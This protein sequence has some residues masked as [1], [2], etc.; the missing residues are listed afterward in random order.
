M[1][2]KFQGKKVILVE[3]YRAFGDMIFGLPFIEHIQRKYPNHHIHAELNFKAYHV[4]E[5]HPAINS[6][7]IYEPDNGEMK[8]R[9]ERAKE[10]WANIEEDLHPEYVFNLQNTI[11]RSC[12]ATEE[13]PEF[14]LSTKERGVKY[15]GT[16]F[17]LAPF[18]KFNEIP[19]PSFFTGNLGEMGY[20]NKEKEWAVRWRSK[21]K[22][23]FVVIIPLAGSTPQKMLPSL[24]PISRWI[25]EEYKNSI[26]YLAGAYMDK[27]ASWMGERIVG[28]FG[29]SFRQL[30]LMA[31]YA[32]LAIGPETGLMAAAGMWG[33]PKIYMATSSSL[34]Q[35]C[36]PTQNDFSVQS[37]VDCA[38]C[39]RSC[40]TVDY[41]PVTING[42]PHCVTGF[43]PEEIKGKIEKVFNEYKFNVRQ[44]G[45][46]YLEEKQVLDKWN[47]FVLPCP[48]CGHENGKYFD[49]WAKCENCGI[50]YQSWENLDHEIYTQA[51][52]D[53]YGGTGK[54][55]LR[56]AEK[57]F[58][59][60]AG[61][62]FFEIGPANTTIME[63][64]KKKGWNSEAIDVA[65]IRSP[66]GFKIYQG[67]FEDIDLTKK[68]D[69]VWA[70]HVFEHFKNPRQ[71]IKKLKG[72]LNDSGYVYIAMPDVA[73]INE[74]EIPTWGHW[75]R[76]EH[77]I[78]FSLAS[79][80]KF[81]IEEGFDVIYEKQNP[82]ATDFICNND[83]HLLLRNK[84][85]DSVAAPSS[86]CP[87][88]GVGGSLSP[89]GPAPSPDG[90]LM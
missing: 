22:D 71:A 62:E 44:K 80:K 39:Y 65:P 4:L 5:N 60:V 72:I 2:N 26:V 67:S 33:T 79:F 66:N 70:S 12:I 49:Y 18:K 85:V 8:T 45:F 88:P 9:L 29:A 56:A 48:L 63:Y 77:H 21:H 59:M 19:C 6:V 46:Q 68:Y 34:S 7:S 38:P 55:F 20:T 43:D 57:Y 23:A 76:K 17:Y 11:E 89:T 81:C 53:M 78:M 24:E 25:T 73:L 47:D 83:F 87:Q 14:W 54:R 1:K 58:P 28:T 69:F 75:A 3:A 42:L 30:S 51:Y 50:V 40:Y 74:E 90:G 35:L 86:L 31:K 41:C 10:R 37:G 13:M 27:V 32:D 84:V 82:G 36:Y 15:S 16:N 64:A 61:R 52:V